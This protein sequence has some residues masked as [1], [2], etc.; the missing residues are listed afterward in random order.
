MK[1]YNDYYI[2]FTDIIKS[3]KEDCETFKRKEEFYNHLWD[4][5]QMIESTLTTV[6]PTWVFDKLYKV[7][8]RASKQASFYN[9]SAHLTRKEIER[10]EKVRDHI[11]TIY[12][13]L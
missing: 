1:K 3:L 11:E 9:Q 7:W 13:D 8:E 5:C 12:I 4:K 2:E 10:L 6:N